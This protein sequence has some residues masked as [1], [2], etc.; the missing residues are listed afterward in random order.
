MTLTET[1]LTE[2]ITSYR[3]TRY[4]WSAASS[5]KV[6]EIIV[7]EVSFALQTPAHIGNGE[8]AKTSDMPLLVDTTDDQPKPLLPG[9]GVAGALRSY[10]RERELG[11]WHA[12]PQPNDPKMV[13]ERNSATV[14]LF[15]GAPGDEYGPDSPLIIDDALAEMGLSTILDGVR[16]SNESGTAA[17]EGLFT[18]ACWLP[19]LSFTVRMELHRPANQDRANLL[20]ALVSALHGFEDG[21]LTLG[22]RTSRGFGQIKTTR[23]RARYFNL[24][25]SPDLKAW[26][27]E[28]DAPLTTCAEA[29]S[30]N[31]E[32]LCDY[33]AATLG[34][35]KRHRVEMVLPLKLDDGLLVG[36]RR[37]HIPELASP[38]L[39]HFYL[40]VPDTAG[41]NRWVPAE[42]GTDMAGK[43]RLRTRKILSLFVKDNVRNKHI[44]T[45]FGHVNDDGQASRLVTHFA[46]LEDAHTDLV[47]HHIRIDRFTG[48]PVDAL[49]FNETPAYGI[50]GHA[51]MK[52]CWTY[53]AEEEKDARAAAG[54]LLLLAKDLI[55][56]R[57]PLGG[58]VSTGMGRFTYDQDVTLSISSPNGKETLTFTPETE[59]PNTQKKLN[60]LVTD[61]LTAFKVLPDEP[62]T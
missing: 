22:A 26:I 3:E 46:P 50:K 19:G 41:N 40:K 53:R 56:R 13:Q 5:R 8:E 35:D 39:T 12:L 28:G 2:T 1:M 33:L 32:D 6:D 29:F 57:L 60:G 11:Y 47:V 30:G 43:L 59:D 21:G 52:V 10:H 15:G 42:T 4:D 20:S 17:H 31:H 58:S 36:S 48:A 54:L 44:D 14:R 25:K 49:L 38:D 7:V 55:E 37:P 16:I 18:T 9:T 24:K 61:L 62:R 34:T 27:R 51:Q 23:Y 45:W